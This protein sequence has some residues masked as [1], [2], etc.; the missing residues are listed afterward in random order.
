VDTPGRWSANGFHIADID[1]TIMSSR[2]TVRQ[3]FPRRGPG[4]AQCCLRVILAV[5]ID[6]VRQTIDKQGVYRGAGALKGRI[7][8][9]LE[10]SAMT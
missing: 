6:W 5:M 8:E 10:V 7:L 1:A 3:L 9:E 2:T 4:P